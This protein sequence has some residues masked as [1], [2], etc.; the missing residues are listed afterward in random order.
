VKSAQVHS[1]GM[2]A[3]CGRTKVSEEDRSVRVSL[4]TLCVDVFIKNI[5]TV[6]VF[7]KLL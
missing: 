4:Q 6:D 3:Q 5:N 2:Y 1:T 7:N